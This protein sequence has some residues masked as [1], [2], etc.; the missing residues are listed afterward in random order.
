MDVTDDDAR[1]RWTFELDGIPGALTVT[2]IVRVEYADNG[3]DVTSADRLMKMGSRDGLKPSIQRNL[4]FEPGQYLI[5]VAHMG[6]PSPG[7]GKGFR[8][9]AGTP[10]LPLDR[11]RFVLRLSTSSE[12]TPCPTTAS[13]I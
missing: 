6:G 3:T 1:K 13:P 11:V 4:L 12:P 8:P 9:Q 5:G 10:L 2:E 7:G